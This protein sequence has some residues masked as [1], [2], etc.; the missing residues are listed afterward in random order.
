MTFADYFRE[1]MKLDPN[2]KLLKQ[3]ANVIAWNIWQIDGL[4]DTVLLGKPYEEY[5]QMSIFDILK[6]AL[7]FELESYCT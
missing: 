2:E 1:R 6:S 7:K 3:F 5:H 4:K